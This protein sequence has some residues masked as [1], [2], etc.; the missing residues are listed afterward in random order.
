MLV[1]LDRWIYR[2][3]A[4]VV[5]VLM[6]AMTAVVGLQVFCR[7]VLNAALIW[8]E[9]LARYAMVWV[10]CLAAGLAVR[11][12]AHMGIDSVIRRLPGPP[13]RAI[14]LSGHVLT[15]AFLA[16]VL[17]AGISMVARVSGQASVALDLPMAV[18]YA[19]V[20]VGAAL[21]LYE[22][23]RLVVGWG[24]PDAAAGAPEAG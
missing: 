24:A 17:V 11:Q 13:R 16:V 6:A 7:Y 4:F 20:P 21:M 19:A 10:T 9:E 12:A 14:V 18:P 8:P 1:T 15:G 23:V 3:A 22:Y 2:A 5:I